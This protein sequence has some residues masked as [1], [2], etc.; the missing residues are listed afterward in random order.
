[1]AQ[2]PSSPNCQE[3]ETEADALGHEILAKYKL[4]HW[5]Y[6]EQTNHVKAQWEFLK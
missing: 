3:L 6:D 2:L 5:D 1:L 4:K